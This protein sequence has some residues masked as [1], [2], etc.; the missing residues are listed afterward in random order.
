MSDLQT[1]KTLLPLQTSA[2][3]FDLDDTLHHRSK[4][5]YGWAREFAQRYHDPAQK[6]ELEGMVDYLVEIDNHGYTPRDEY[7]TR[8]QRNY[9]QVSGSHEQLI[10]EYQRDVIGHIVLEDEILYLLQK[11]QAQQIPFGIVTNGEAQQQKRKIQTLG[12]DA[13]TDC[14]FVSKEFG[15]QKPDPSIFLAAA[16]CLQKPTSEILF[17]GDNPEFDIWGAH[18]VG[19]KTV[20]IHHAPRQWPEQISPEVADLTVRTFADLLPLLGLHP[21]D[22]EM[23]G[24]N[25]QG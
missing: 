18:Q 17:V 15:A 12:I 20:W 11:L 2:L 14:I 9:P 16:Q 4:A 7:F 5:F 13:F 24:K 23:N 22:A 8:V 19:M 21:G 6:A 3:L 1:K 10:A 25:K